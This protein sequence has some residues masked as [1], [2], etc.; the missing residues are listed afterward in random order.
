M[1]PNGRPCPRRLCPNGPGPPPGARPIRLLL[2][3]RPRCSPCRGAGRPVSLEPLV[4]AA[5]VCRSGKSVGTPS[6]HAKPSRADETHRRRATCT[7]SVG[8]ASSAR[9]GRSSRGGLAR[10]LGC[11]RRGTRPPRAVGWRIFSGCQRR[12]LA[13]LNPDCLGQCLQLGVGEARY[14]RQ[15]SGD[16]CPPLVCRRWGDL[17]IPCAP[18]ELW[19]LQ[20]PRRP[21][22]A[23]PGRRRRRPIPR[24]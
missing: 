3:A 1:S 8:T 12:T 21:A 17:R 10:G 7:L 16:V 6:P 24:C 18:R 2:R 11:L 20:R 4:C 13:L 15:E 23:L 22:V 19:S 5:D 14:L 9:A